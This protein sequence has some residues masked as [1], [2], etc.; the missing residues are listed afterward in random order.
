M[1]KK[2]YLALVLALALAAAMALSTA[3]C[4][5]KESGGA[6]SAG[7]AQEVGQG[8][9]TF[10]FQ[11][12][13]DDKTEVFTVKTDKATVGEALLESGLIAGTV[14]SYGL[15]VKSVNGLELDYDS[16]G[17]YWAFYVNGEY[18]MAGVDATEIKE[19]DI[20]ELRKEKG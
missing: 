11:T 10:T 5:K 13:A 20:Y 16:D 8:A 15:Y 6:A 12:T 14:E 9:T 3:A 17:A 19:G 18:A 4:S 1:E 7:A 2:R